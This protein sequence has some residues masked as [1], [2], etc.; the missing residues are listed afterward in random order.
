MGLQT[1]IVVSVLSIVACISVMVTGIVAILMSSVMFQNNET[2]VMSNIKGCLYGYRFGAG[3][4]DIYDLSTGSRQPVL[5]YRDCEVVDDFALND[6]LKNV[7]FGTEEKFIEYIFVFELDRES[8]SEV[9]VDLENASITSQMYSANYQ[10]CYQKEEPTLSEW[11]NAK[12]VDGTM[13]VNKSN[14][15]LWLRASLGIHHGDYESRGL[16]THCI[17]TFTFSFKEGAVIN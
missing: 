12:A 5:L 15:Y 3:D 13:V 14:K 4:H 10:Y 8:Q 7:T 17:W 1:K 16:E 2:L 11:E 9:W 6:I